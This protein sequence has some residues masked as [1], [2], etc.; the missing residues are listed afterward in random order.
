M[1]DTN[2]EWLEET[3]YQAPMIAAM[4]SLSNLQFKIHFLEGEVLKE[5]L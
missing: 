5:M 1:L 3:F 4:I 2:S